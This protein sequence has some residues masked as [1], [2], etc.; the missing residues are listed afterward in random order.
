MRRGF[1]SP[2]LHFTPVP[3]A[4]YYSHLTVRERARRAPFVYAL[5]SCFPVGAGERARGEGTRVRRRRDERERMEQPYDAA[6]TPHAGSICTLLFVSW[7]EKKQV[8]YQA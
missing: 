7:L 1:I 6:I 5:L 4:P 3:F 2:P 8:I